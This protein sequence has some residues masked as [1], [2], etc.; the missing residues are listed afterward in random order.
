MATGDGVCGGMVG[1]PGRTVQSE[2]TVW[3][4]KVDEHHGLSA[5]PEAAGSHTPKAKAAA[6]AASTA[7]PPA[8]SISTPAAVAPTCAVDTIPP[9]AHWALDS[10]VALSMSPGSVLVF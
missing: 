6:T 5:R 4:C 2:G 10:F 7:L 1:C 9:L 3:F 8:S